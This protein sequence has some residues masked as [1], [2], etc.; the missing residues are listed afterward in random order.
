MK[1]QII[2]PEKD[3]V[4]IAK[5]LLK[6]TF[7]MIIISFFLKLLGFNFFDADTSNKILLWISDFIYYFNL[8]Y[9]ISFI[10]IFVQTFIFLRLSCKNKNLK[11]YFIS[12]IILT[13][14]N[15]I[16]QLLIHNYLSPKTQNMYSFIFSVFSLIIL[17]TTTI[18]ID[19]KKNY[20]DKNDTIFKKIWHRIK[21]PI[22]FSILIF[23][24]QFITLFIRDITAVN[25]YKYLYNFLLNFDFMIL[26]LLTYYL[27]LKKENNIK[28][29]RES[30]FSLVSLLNNIPSKEEVKILVSNLKE[31]KEKFNKLSKFDKT[32]NVLYTIFFIIGECINLGIVIFI[33]CLNNYL[34]ECLFIILAFQ[35]TKKTFGAFHFKS[36]IVCFVVSNISFYILSKLTATVDITF[37]VPAAFG[38]LLG[39]IASKFIKKTD[40]APYRGMAKEHLENICDGKKL[41]KIEIDILNDYF[42]NKETLTRLTM[43]Y[44]YSQTQIC[45]FKK[46][47]LAKLYA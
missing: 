10:I 8:Y 18:L 13:L 2:L 1:K 39:Y 28:K 34:I 35:I 31:N 36:F 7:I 5:L 4:L 33:A 17:L 30:D 42:C 3:K 27:F 41:K 25:R 44:N 15:I 24:Y 6:I 47:A 22:I 14:F 21:R 32:V 38:I 46:T 26:L 9:I 45:R 11:I 20:N 23:I 19:V 37:V 43:K 12:S 29:I 16:T 40:V